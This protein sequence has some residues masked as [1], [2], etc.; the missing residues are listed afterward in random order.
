MEIKVDAAGKQYIVQIFNEK[1]KNHQGVSNKEIEKSAVM[2]E[3]PENLD[4]CPIKTFKLYLTKLNPKCPALFQRPLKNF[5]NKDIWYDNAPLGHN[6]IGEMMK[7]IST[8]AGL[9]KTYT[10]H[11]I[12]TTTSTVL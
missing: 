5:A 4:Q 10:N 9:S 6:I 8:D 3:Q 7:R 1:E 11:C 12:R 2:Y